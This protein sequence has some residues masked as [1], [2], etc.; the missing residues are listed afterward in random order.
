MQNPHFPLADFCAKTLFP[1]EFASTEQDGKIPAEGRWEG[2][3]QRATAAE[4][5]WP[6]LESTVLP[7]FRAAA[8]HAGTTDGGASP[9][10][11]TDSLGREPGQGT[12]PSPE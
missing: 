4:E 2:S 10:L 1:N 5:G 7:I 3:A 8:A 11:R 12:L 6:W 9:A